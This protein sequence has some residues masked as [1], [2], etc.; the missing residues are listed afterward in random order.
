MHTYVYMYVCTDTYM[1]VYDRYATCIQSYA[2]LHDGTHMHISLSSNTQWLTCAKSTHNAG[3]IARLTNNPTSL[4]QQWCSYY[5]I[6]LYVTPF[7]GQS[8][9]SLHSRLARPPRQVDSDS[10]QWDFKPRTPTGNEIQVSQEFAWVI[11][12]MPIA[13]E[14]LRVTCKPTQQVVQRV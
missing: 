9:G 7:T 3:T 1:C 13:L 12:S 2:A 6:L 10:A 4:V 5:H 14:A 8:Y 11:W